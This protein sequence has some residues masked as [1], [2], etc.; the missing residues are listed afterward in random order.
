MRRII[1]LLVAVLLL[2]VFV[3]AAHAADAVSKTLID[4]TDSTVD[5]LSLWQTT[6]DAKT[7]FCVL[8][9]TAYAGTGTRGIQIIMCDPAEMVAGGCVD[10]T[11]GE[12]FATSATISAVD[13]V[14]LV[15]NAGGVITGESATWSDTE[16][17]GMMPLHWI[18][19]GNEAGGANT[20][21]YTID[22]TWW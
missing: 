17:Y 6:P 22:C 9:L 2:F 8:D 12:V 15:V 10:D 7:I 21:T 4:V 14:R 19:R 11:D 20:V 18:M 3:G 5:D 1:G 16:V 13:E